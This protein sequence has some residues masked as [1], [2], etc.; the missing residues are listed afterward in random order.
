M[1]DVPID[2]SEQR[3]ANLFDLRGVIAVVTG[4]GTGIGLMISSTL[5]AN[6]ATVYI[7]GPKQEDLDRVAKIYNDASGKIVGEQGGKMIGIA[8]DVSHK[9][10]AKRLAQEI[11][12]REPYVTVLFNN[13]G[14]TGANLKLPS[15]NTA[16]AYHSAVFDQIQPDQFTNILNTNAVGPFWLTFAFL[17]L[18]EKWKNSEEPV[19]KRFVPQVVM[20]SSMNGWTK[21][22]S[23]GGK[24]FPYLFSKSALGHATSSL[25]HELLPLGVRVNGIAPGL[26]PT[27]MTLP[28]RSSEAGITQVP[29][30]YLSNLQFHSPGGLGTKRDM[31]ALALCLVANW[32]INGETVLIDGGTL[33]KH[34]SSY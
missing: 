28:G 23:T 2:L 33:L 17:P 7:V 3:A 1:S 20:T 29:P 26:F 27:E 14:I 22:S 15:T 8:G 31:G 16:E 6:G 12:S 18:L 4:G 32:F 11:A 19:T 5:V 25:A 9:E 34:P 10:E 30:N 24:S 13:A 21:D